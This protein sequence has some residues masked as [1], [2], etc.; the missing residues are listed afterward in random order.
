MAFFGKQKIE[1]KKILDTNEDDVKINPVDVLSN[2]ILDMQYGDL[3]Q[4]GKELLVVAQNTKDENVNTASSWAHFMFKWAEER[5]NKDVAKVQDG[6]LAY[7]STKN[8]LLYKGKASMEKFYNEATTGS[9]DLS[10]VSI[11]NTTGPLSDWN[12]LS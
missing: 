2:T 12:K 10:S 8:V 7:D 6:N 1:D 11:V 9:A 5:K 3:L 4:F